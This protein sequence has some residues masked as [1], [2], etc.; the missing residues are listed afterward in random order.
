MDKIKDAIKCSNC[1]NILSS[2]V[3]LPCSHSI[4]RRHVEE[5]NSDV[6]TC[7][8]CEKDHRKQEYTLNQALM[9]IIEAQIE[10][11]DFGEVHKNAKK[12]CDQ[13]ELVIKEIEQLLN[14]P[15]NFTHEEIN[16]LQRQLELKRE[17]MKKRIDDEF[18]KFY[19]KLQDYKN[20]CT[21]NLASN[22]YSI[23]SGKISLGLKETREKLN[24]WLRVLD[25]LKVSNEPK[26]KNIIA[27]SEKFKGN[28]E[29]ELNRFKQNLLLEK[30]E[31]SKSEV[32]F[33]Q[34]NINIET[35]FSVVFDYFKR[36]RIFINFL[37]F[38]FI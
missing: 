11:L 22:K 23:L 33:I 4:C 30:F 32:A 10:A 17:E 6:I 18:D 38:K 2:P 1:R 36:L 14:D 26:W 3:I 5:V 31:N 34:K 16:E 27:E 35:L 28:L 7:Y 29:A 21:Q 9:Q 19:A 13:L 15:N 25:E 8:K 37:C 20:E 12:S 24:E